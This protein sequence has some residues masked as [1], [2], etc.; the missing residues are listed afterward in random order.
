MIPQM[1][2]I[3][4]FFWQLCLLRSSP[5]RLPQSVAALGIIIAAY[6]VVAIGVLGVTRP[7]H[8]LLAVIGIVFTGALVQGTLTYGL[9]AFKRQAN[10][11]FATWGALLGTNTIML[12]I[13]LPV[14]L[15]I[16]NIEDESLKR[17]ADSISWVCLG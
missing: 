12:V 10:R 9:L 4:G 16:L 8:S 15:T 17:V 7:T 5:A 2:P 14:N 11:F 1:F 13:L 6:C 3:L